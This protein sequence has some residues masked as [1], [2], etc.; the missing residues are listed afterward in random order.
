FHGHPM[1]P[2]NSPTRHLERRQAAGQPGAATPDDPRPGAAPITPATVADIF[3]T[4]EPGIIALDEDEL[5]DP[6]RVVGTLVHYG[7]SVAWDPDDPEHDRDIASQALL[8]QFPEGLRDEL[9]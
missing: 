5:P 2:V 7:I 9:I 4:S 8:Q 3:A 6:N 1:P